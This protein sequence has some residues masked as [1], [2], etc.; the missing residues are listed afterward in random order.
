L[1]EFTDSDVVSLICPRPLLVQCGKK[2]GIA[3]W[4]QVVEEFEAAR[5]HYEKLG[6]AERFE[7]DLHEGGHEAIIESGVRFLT[8]WLMGKP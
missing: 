5:V 2:D 4:P 3:H 8:R 7:M 6:L 1:T